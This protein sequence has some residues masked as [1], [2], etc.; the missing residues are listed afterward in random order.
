MIKYS[1][2]TTIYNSAD[3]VEEFLSFTAKL[4]NDESELV[5]VDGGSKDGTYQKLIEM[6]GFSSNIHVYREHCT[7]GRGRQIAIEKADGKTIIMIDADYKLNNVEKFLEYF[8]DNRTD[9]IILFEPGKMIDGSVLNCVI[10]L[11]E[12][13]LSVGGY[14]DLNCAEDIYFFSVAEKLG[15]LDTKIIDPFDILPMKIRGKN[16]GVESRYALSFIEVVLR[17]IIITR[18]SLFVGKKGYSEICESWGLTGAKKY[19][20]GTP[21]YT[22]GKILKLGIREETLEKRINRLLS[23]N[24]SQH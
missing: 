8:E 16:S 7:R 21:L 6:K 15:R 5:I 3:T 10:G 2:C 20:I 9:K 18:D 14:P 24:N 13:F 4:L 11:R 23:E 19:L 12:T 17:R 1:Y 22:L